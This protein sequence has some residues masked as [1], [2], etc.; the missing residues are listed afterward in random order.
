MRARMVLL[1][2][3]GNASSS[4]AILGNAHADVAPTT[5]LHPK[6]GHKPRPMASCIAGAQALLPRASLAGSRRSH[7]ARPVVAGAFGARSALGSSPQLASRRVHAV[8]RR[9]ALQ[10]VNVAEMPSTASTVDENL[11]VLQAHPSSDSAA[12]SRADRP[13]ERSSEAV[14]LPGTVPILRASA[15][16]V[17]IDAT[18]DPKHT[19]LTIRATNRPGVLNSITATLKDLVLNVSKAVVDLEGSVVAGESS[20]WRAR[21]GCVSMPCARVD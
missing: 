2:V 12:V 14:R 19:I 6:P 16:Q 3:P 17:S 9:G 13:R 11:Q 1:G 4:D 7:G 8:G 21:G 10:V 5:F 15:S 20:S 18:S